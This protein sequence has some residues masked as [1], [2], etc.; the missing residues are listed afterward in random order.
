MAR[1]ASVVK[2]WIHLHKVVNRGY[3]MKNFIVTGVMAVLGAVAVPAQAEVVV[4][5]SIDV[6]FPAF[7]PCAN[8]G[9][10]EVVDLKGRL[11]IL[12]TLNINKNRISGKTHFQP[13]G[14]SGY[15]SITG[16]KYQGVGVTQSHFSGSLEGGQFNRTFVNNFRIIGQGPG[17]NYLVHQNFHLTVNANGEVST[18]HDNFKIDC[19]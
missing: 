7:V 4:N 10:G 18:A 5:E 2:R 16:V 11:H 8:G 19:K 3:V 6:E 13:Q 15:G 17:N 9:N 12:I 14:L 1:K